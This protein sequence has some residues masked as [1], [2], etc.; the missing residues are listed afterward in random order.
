LEIGMINGWSPGEVLGFAIVIALSV[1]AI[2]YSRSLTEFLMRFTS[3]TDW[4]PTSLPREDRP[5]RLRQVRE[6]RATYRP[7]FR[8]YVVLFAAAVFV[9]CV[10]VLVLG[11]E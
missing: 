7:V 6:V 10:V 5:E 2:V 1:V 9:S 8:F 3:Y 11:G 4:P